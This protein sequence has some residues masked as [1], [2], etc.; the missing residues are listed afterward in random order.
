MKE[1]LERLLQYNKEM[2]YES[3]LIGDDT[4][5][6]GYAQALLNMKSAIEFELSNLEN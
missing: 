2:I 3:T 4:Y 6:V 1:L 5:R